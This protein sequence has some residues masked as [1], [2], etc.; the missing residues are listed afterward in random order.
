MF[1]LFL[2]LKQSKLY[3]RKRLTQVS[4]IIYSKYLFENKVLVYTI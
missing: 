1:N 2:T 3:H 4:H